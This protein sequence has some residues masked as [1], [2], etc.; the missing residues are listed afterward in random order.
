MTSDVRPAAR[1]TNWPL[2]ALISFAPMVFLA[3]VFTHA[4]AVASADSASSAIASSP[5][6]GPTGL[7]RPTVRVLSPT[8]VLITLDTNGTES[9]VRLAIGDTLTDRY[10]QMDGSLGAA[11]AYQTLDDWGAGNG[12]VVTVASDTDYRFVAIAEETT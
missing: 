8:K 7:W 4:P 1:G 5:V 11:P 6:S 12:V 10:V 9:G 3:I 2:L